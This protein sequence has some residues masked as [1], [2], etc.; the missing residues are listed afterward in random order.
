MS[1]PFKLI[2]AI[3]VY[4]AAL[5]GLLILAAG[6]YGLFEYM[7]SILF[8]N[9]SFDALYAITPLARIT[10][11]LLIMVPHWAIGHHFHLVEHKAKK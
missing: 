7:L 3:Y 4:T 11:G 10:T 2:K 5:V 1:T 9:V 6:F 8:I